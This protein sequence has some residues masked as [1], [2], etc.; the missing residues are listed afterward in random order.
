MLKWKLA[1]KTQQRVRNYLLKLRDKCIFT[2]LIAHRCAIGYKLKAHFIN[3]SQWIEYEF[4]KEDKKSHNSWVRSFKIHITGGDFPW[5]S[6][7]SPQINT[8]GFNY[9]SAC[10]RFSLEL[11]TFLAT[12]LFL[13]NEALKFI[14][15]CYLW[16]RKLF[17]NRFSY[18]KFQGSMGEYWTNT[19][20]PK[21]LM[22]AVKWKRISKFPHFLIPSA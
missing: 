17:A 14:I 7:C 11:W 16:Y 19:N 3:R 2:Y 5:N 9:F 21:P 10:G 22:A 8:R 13:V 12:F 4:T 6:F 20:V 1:I 15:V 18:R